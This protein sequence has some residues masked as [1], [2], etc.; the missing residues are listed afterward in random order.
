[1]APNSGLDVLSSGI[2]VSGL[3]VVAGGEVADPLSV[4]GGEAPKSG[5][6]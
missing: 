1:V 3:D 5:L 4:G 6:S 2:L